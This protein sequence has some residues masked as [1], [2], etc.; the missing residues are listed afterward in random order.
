MANQMKATEQ[1]SVIVLRFQVMITNWVVL[2]FARLTERNP[3][4]VWVFFVAA[5]AA[6]IFSVPFSSWIMKG[7]ETS[8]ISLC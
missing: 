5:S 7:S 4:R 1:Y 3:L 2:T 8:L 6:F